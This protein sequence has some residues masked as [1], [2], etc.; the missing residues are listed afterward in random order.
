MAGPD[1]RLDQLLSNQDNTRSILDLMQTLLQK[2]DGSPA[3][4]QAQAPSANGN[5]PEQSTAPFPSLALLL[6]QLMQAMSGE[7]NMIKQER[8]ALLRAIRPYLK[9]N[10]VQSLDRALRIANM[11]KAA[12]T[13]LKTLGR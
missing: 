13:A 11:T 1:E 5:T 6:P 2:Q 3:P 12:S 10:R 4:A 8:V 9:E 7:G